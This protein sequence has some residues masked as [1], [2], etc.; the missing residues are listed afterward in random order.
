MTRKFSLIVILLSLAG[1]FA[2][3]TVNAQSHASFWTRKGVAGATLSQVSLSNWST[4]GEGSAAYNLMLNYAADYKN[5]K[6][7][8][9][10]RIELAYGMTWSDSKGSQKNNDRIFLTSMYGYEIGRN[11]YFSLTGTFQS[12]FANGFDYNLTPKR[13]IS[14]FLAPGYISVGPGLTWKPSDWFTATFSPLTWRGTIV[15]DDDLFWDANGAPVSAYGVK[16]GKHFLNELGANVRLEAKHDIAR[17]INLYSRLDLFS[18][19]LH[20][21]Q[22]VDVQWDVVVTAALTKWL[23]AN[24]TLNMLYDDDIKFPRADGSMGGSKFQIREILG[25]GLQTTF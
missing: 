22:N 24:L 14:R 4:G 7:L 21:P 13:K 3:S 25:L 18:D 2:A 10:N 17:N 23:S 6:H 16:H 12:Q 19:Y 9:N 15:L 8:W 20:K 11:W 1:G 5:G